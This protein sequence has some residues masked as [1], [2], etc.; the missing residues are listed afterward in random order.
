MVCTV[1]GQRNCLN[2]TRLLR[3]KFSGLK[4]EL[5]EK[6]KRQY[7][8]K[9]IFCSMALNKKTN[10]GKTVQPKFTSWESCDLPAIQGG[11][12]VLSATGGHGSGSLGGRYMNS[13]SRITSTGVMR[14]ENE[15]QLNPLNR[16]G[17]RDNYE[18]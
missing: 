14:L 17:R 10:D 2:F 16:I 6:L 12:P 13:Y 7:P 5:D 3:V 9:K 4:V 1:S 11:F 18:K 8:G 15:T